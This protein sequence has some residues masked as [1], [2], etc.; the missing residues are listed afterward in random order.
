[1]NIVNN[2]FC[3]HTYA[4]N[5]RVGIVREKFGVIATVYVHYLIKVY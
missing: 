2:C 3:H 4:R 1:M 5:V